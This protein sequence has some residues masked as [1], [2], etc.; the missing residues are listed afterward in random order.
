MNE[1]QLRKSAAELARDIRKMERQYPGWSIKEWNEH[2]RKTI[3]HYMD[4]VR[5]FFKA[6]GDWDETEV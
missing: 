6:N 5:Y 4:S 2:V 3:K 1:Q